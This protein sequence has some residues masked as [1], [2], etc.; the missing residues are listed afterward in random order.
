M[1]CLT[2]AP[3]K[4][5]PRALP[6]CAPRQDP[7]PPW[8]FWP[9][10]AFLLMLAMVAEFWFLGIGSQAASSNSEPLER[11]P[12]SELVLPESGVSRE[13]SQIEIRK[14][15]PST[16]LLETLGAWSASQIYQSYLNIGMLADSVAHQAYGEEEAFTILST[17]TGLLNMMDRQ[18]EKVAEV[19]EPDD[20][21]ALERIRRLNHL[22]QAQ[23]DALVISWETGDQKKE[24]EYLQIREKSWEGIR[25]IL[26]IE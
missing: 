24:D 3:A 19:V 4:E 7:S 21:Q 16:L 2:E 15:Q 1:K 22:L 9:H 18:M 5:Y 6:Y 23:A 11:Q 26:G 14:S 13:K 10:V 12:K 8:R 20:Q 25:E 17:L